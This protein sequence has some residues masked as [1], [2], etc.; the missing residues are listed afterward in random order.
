MLTY[1]AI[2]DLADLTVTFLIYGDY[3]VASFG[4]CHCTWLMCQLTFGCSNVN[5]LAH[6]NNT[7]NCTGC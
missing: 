6:S 3:V 7:N 5:T 2:H 4:T 1:Y